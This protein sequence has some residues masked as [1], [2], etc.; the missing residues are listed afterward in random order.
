[1]SVLHHDEDKTKPARVVKPK[2]DRHLLN[3]MFSAM[4]TVALFYVGRDFYRIFKQQPVDKDAAKSDGIYKEPIV[5][6]N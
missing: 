3:I 4:A 2:F 6:N 1:M 5:L